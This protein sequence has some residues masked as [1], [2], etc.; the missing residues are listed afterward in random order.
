MGP[1][2]HL[3]NTGLQQGERASPDGVVPSPSKALFVSPDR[4]AAGNK[5]STE[6]F[7][8]GLFTSTVARSGNS[9]WRLYLDMFR[10]S[11]LNPRPWYTWKVELPTSSISVLEVTSA[12]DWVNFVDKYASIGHET[13]IYP[14]WHAVARDFDGIHVTMRAIVASQGLSFVTSHGMTAPAYWDMGA[15]VVAALDF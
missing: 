4:A 9:M 1:Y 15:N 13:L 5:L 7:G 6:P 12:K 2:A 8:L 3:D 10:A 11:I 14:N